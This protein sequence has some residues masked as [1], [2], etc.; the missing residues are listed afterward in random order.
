MIFSCIK[1]NVW[2]FYCLLL[3]FISSCYTNFMKHTP[4]CA[5]KIYNIFDKMKTI[6]SEGV[7]EFSYGEGHWAADKKVESIFVFYDHDK[8]KTIEICKF[9]M[10]GHTAEGIPEEHEYTNEEFALHMNKYKIELMERQNIE[11][12]ILLIN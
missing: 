6:S 8:M 7:L 10:G 3:P 5:A 1:H 4:E 2:D 11:S 12:I 9:P